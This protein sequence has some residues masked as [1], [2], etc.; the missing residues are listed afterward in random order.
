M[1]EP[2]FALVKFGLGRSTGTKSAAV[3]V[4]AEAVAKAKKVRRLMGW[5]GRHVLL[6]VGRQRP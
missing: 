3:A 1:L 6:S 2:N 5:T 4:I